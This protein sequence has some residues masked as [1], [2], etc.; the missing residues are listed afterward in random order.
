MN[1]PTQVQTSVASLA[2]LTLGALVLAACDPEPPCWKDVQ[3]G[4]TYHVSLAAKPSPALYAVGLPDVPPC[5]GIDS[6]GAGRAVDI[7]IP[8]NGTHA[9]H[10]PSQCWVPRGFITSDVGLTLVP[11]DARAGF[12]VDYSSRPMFVSSAQFS[13]GD[14][15]GQW[16]FLTVD[17]PANA[18][19]GTAA[20]RWASRLAWLDASAACQT[21]F[22]AIATPSRSWCY[23]EWDIDVAAM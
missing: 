9:E 15:M 12:D 7:A 14:C 13:I 1:K 23:E 3:L 21:A 5:T 18:Y 11:V 8:Q 10:D 6:L 17:E 20:H 16:F 4:A 19:D 22:P 2:A